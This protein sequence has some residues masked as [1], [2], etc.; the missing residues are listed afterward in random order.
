MLHKKKGNRTFR[1][2]YFMW[3]NIFFLLFD[4]AS[5]QKGNHATIDPGMDRVIRRKYESSINN[6][7][8]KFTLYG[9]AS[10]KAHY[11]R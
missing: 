9:S 2:Y 10:K 1:S 5:K 3:S 8:Q 4:G 11:L 6:A 7:A